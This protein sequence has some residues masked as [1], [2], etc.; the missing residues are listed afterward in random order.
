MRDVRDGRTIG[1]IEIMRR[2][3]VSLLALSAA[4]PLHAE[5]AGTPAYQLAVELAGTRSQGLRGMLFDD[6]GQPLGEAAPGAQ[7]ETP[8]G[9]FAWQPCAHLWSVCGWLE[10]GMIAAWPGG[11]LNAQVEGGPELYRVVRLE[12]GLWRGELVA[13]GALLPPGDSPQVTAMGSFLPR[14]GGTLSGWVPGSWAA[15]APAAD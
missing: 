5:P 4:L 9:T 15:A 7:V 6:A 14:E 8:F 11:G 1:G 12:G 13:A 2:V 10:A 3:L